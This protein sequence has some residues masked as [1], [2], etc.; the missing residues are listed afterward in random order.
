MYVRTYPLTIFIAATGIPI[1]IFISTVQSL[2]TGL[3]LLG[4]MYSVA[5]PA[6]WVAIALEEGL[7]PIKDKITP[8]HKYL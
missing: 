8:L 6:A 2:P 7:E 1:L 4:L 5:T 3:Q